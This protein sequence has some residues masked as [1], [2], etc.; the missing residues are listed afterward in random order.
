MP[1]KSFVILLDG[2]GESCDSEATVELASN[3]TLADIA[4]LHERLKTILDSGDPV[5]IDAGLVETVDTAVLQLL[6][7]FARSARARKVDVQWQGESGA[8]NE[9]AR[10]LGLDTE[11]S[12]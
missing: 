12:L 2:S 11:L 1:D 3:S 4:D 7:S 8:L 5:S 9:T 10:C 6:C